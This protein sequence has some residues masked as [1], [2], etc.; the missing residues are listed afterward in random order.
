MQN[1]AAL[2]AQGFAQMAEPA[3]LLVHENERVRICHNVP[4][5]NSVRGSSFVHFDSLNG[6]APSPTVIDGS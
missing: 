3:V 6:S 1:P 5:I 2:V 4:I